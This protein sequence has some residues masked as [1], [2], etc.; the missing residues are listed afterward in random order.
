MLRSGARR[1]RGRGGQ[2]R[3]PY[4]GGVERRRAERYVEPDWSA[5]YGLLITATGWTFDYIDSH[6]TFSRYNRLV[7]YWSQNPPLHLLLGAHF[8]AGKPAGARAAK[9]VRYDQHS[10]AEL[11]SAWRAV[12]GAVA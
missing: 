8:A 6:V 5:I 3:A 2:A 7:E 12:G 11:L 4:A 1:G 9:V 10:V